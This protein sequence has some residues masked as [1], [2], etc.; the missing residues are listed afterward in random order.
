[1]SILANRNGA[2]LNRQLVA[3][4]LRY[5][6]GWAAIFTD[7]ELALALY[8]QELADRGTLDDNV[9]LA[10]ILARPGPVTPVAGPALPS[11]PSPPVVGRFEVPQLT[12]F[13]ND[14][15][16]DEFYP[17]SIRFAFSQAF[18]E[19][20]FNSC[21]SVMRVDCEACS[22][23]CTGWNVTLPCE[24]A[25]DLNCFARLVETSLIGPDR[26]T[27]S[28]PPKCC[29]QDIPFETVRDHLPAALAARFTARLEE[30]AAQEVD[31]SACVSRSRG[32]RLLCD[33]A[34]DPDCL[35]MLVETSLADPVLFPPRCC[36][37]EIS[38][39]TIRNQ[40]PPAL[41]A[42]VTA[43]LGEMIS[44]AACFDRCPD[45]SVVLACN[46]VYDS[47][48]FT[49]LVE[50][51]LTDADTD[52]DA[53]P[54]PPKCCGGEIP[55]DTIRYHLP[56]TLVARVT[57]R[58]DEIAPECSACF[59]RHRGET[60]RLPCHHVYDPE[61]IALLVE[62]SL[63]DEE[64]DMEP[65]HFPPKCCGQEISLEDIRNQLPAALVARV[66]ARLDAIFPLCVTCSNRCRSENVRLPCNHAYDPDCF[67]RLVEASLSNAEMDTDAD[68]SRDMEPN[69]TPVVFPPKCCE[70][71]IPLNTIRDLVPAALY[72]RVTAKLE[73][74]A[75]PPVD[76]SA[77]FVP[78]T[79]G[80]L[81]LACEHVY[82][83]E[84]FAMLAEASLSDPVLFPP[85]CCG[86]EI[87]SDIVRENIPDALMT[88]IVARLEEITNLP[89][90]YC[91]NPTCSANLG[92]RSDDPHPLMCTSCGTDTCCACASTHPV[93]MTCDQN[94]DGQAVAELAKQFGWKRCPECRRMVEHNHGCYHMTCICS[95]Q[96]C[97]H[98]VAT[99]R[100]CTCPQF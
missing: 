30:I 16:Q 44:C 72:A 35:A 84:C 31:C 73:E 17:R 7:E 32:V 87:P 26:G 77:C 9:E 4:A 92:P 88:R 63:T 51:S 66:L 78:C 3:P 8:V 52:T 59:I 18:G 96:F 19:L 43:R 89:A 71:E 85:K 34:Y 11:P 10:Q 33:D 47:E 42:R 21:N 53:I 14:E 48:C 1:M 38:L 5:D 81:K 70:Q 97:Y 49:L 13:P 39:D 2:E 24:H 90:V 50:A 20:N 37:Q 93:D 64:A 6:E 36:G 95:K 46:H 98:C 67:A 56:T 80:S 74:L 40:L 61:C 79:G 54:F 27:D 99:W 60:I 55:L 15:I 94:V 65:V 45:T 75:S 62:A 57:A 82:D 100:T 68:P 23:P 22:S 28:F 76:C 69:T 83:P 25:Y 58:L 29:G 41:V 91:A 86:Q 12:R